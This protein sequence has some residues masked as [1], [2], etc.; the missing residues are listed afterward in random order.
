[1][2]IVW[3]FYEEN[4][5]WC[6]RVSSIKTSVI[7]FNYDCQENCEDLLVCFKVF[8]LDILEKHTF[9]FITPR[10]V[11]IYKLYS[12]VNHGNEKK[13]KHHGIMPEQREGGMQFLYCQLPL[14]VIFYLVDCPRCR[15]RKA[16]SNYLHF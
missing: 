13:I 9:L 14:N 7:N 16:Q 15:H 2:I 8:L 4:G 1:M 3:S 11:L 6:Q 5:P 10:T 12:T